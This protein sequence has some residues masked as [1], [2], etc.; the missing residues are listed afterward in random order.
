MAQK[1]ANQEESNEQQSLTLRTKRCQ[2]FRVGNVPSVSGFASGSKDRRDFSSIVLCLDSPWL[3]SENAKD[4]SRIEDVP[5]NGRY[6]PDRKRLFL[7]ELDSAVLGAAFV[8]RVVRY[9]LMASLSNRA[10]VERVDTLLF[11]S[12][13]DRF[14]TLL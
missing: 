3:L 4:T 6:A 11:Q 7:Y 13:D 14:R 1:A 2:V 12:L 8:C 5:C 10:K 9:G